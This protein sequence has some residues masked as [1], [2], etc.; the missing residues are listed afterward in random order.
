MHARRVSIILFMSLSMAGCPEDTPAEDTGV[1]TG[2]T[3]DVM[4]V[5]ACGEAQIPAAD[6]SA[7]MPAATDYQPRDAMSANDT[8]AACVSDDGTYTLV[9]STPSS[10]ARVEAYEQI[11]DLLWRAGTPD[12]AAFTAAR[13]VYSLEEGLESRLVRREDLH[14]PPIPE[15]DFDPGVDPDKQ[16]TVEANVIAHADR[17]AGPTKI[18]PIIERAFDDGQLGVGDPNVHAARIDAAI[19]WFYY[20]SV[21]KECST[22][23][24]NA[25]DCDSCWAYYTGGNDRSGGIGLSGLVRTQSDATHNRV[26]DGFLSVRCWRDLYPPEMYETFD[27]VPVEGRDLFAQG[28]G[29][30]DT[31]LHRAFAIVVRDRLERQLEVCET[32]AAAANWA[33]LQV[34]GPV[35]D[36]EAQE[37]DA[38][39]AA[40]LSS[41][42]AQD[43]PTADDIAAGAAALDAIFPCS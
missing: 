31:A 28:H 27:D 15:E 26:W 34:A 8:W 12:T 5:F 35:L 16:C 33:F 23:T 11:A 39:N 38:G 20:I 2:D 30:L 32:E 4:G 17:C 7:C 22:C 18:A 10:I 37:R 29:Q 3:G 14:Y 40:T 36:R 42:W 24:N 13:D 1:A 6:E 21:Y 43:D 41:L 25:A 19:L 9:E